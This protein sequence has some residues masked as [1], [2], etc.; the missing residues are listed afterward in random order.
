[1]TPKT[2]MVIAG[3][4]SGDI[5]A[6]ELV[7]ALRVELARLEADGLVLKKAYLSGS[8]DRILASK[9][10]FY[11]RICSGAQ[12]ALAFDII[13]ALVLRTSSLRTPSLARKERQQQ[14]VKEIDAILEAI[15]ARNV[16]AAKRAAIAHVENAAVAALDEAQ[17]LPAKASA[18][19]KPARKKVAGAARA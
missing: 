17:A 16:A 7:E 14:S 10:A 5:L 13:N 6:A 8:V 1:M 3:D 11:D 9:H 15:R 19:P 18:G 2:I 4:P 12:N